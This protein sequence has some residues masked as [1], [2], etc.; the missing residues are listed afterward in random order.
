MKDFFSKYKSSDLWCV[1][2]EGFNKK[3]QAIRESQLS[4]GNGF[5]GSRGA[6]EEA[7]EG[8][9][10][11][12]YINGI[13][14]RLTSQVAELVN[15]PN[16][17][18]F[19]ITINGEK[20]GTV[21]MDIVE[22]ERILN[23]QNGLV[24]RHT[25]Y[26][27]VK[28]RRY[29]YQSVRFVSAA[30]KNFGAIRIFLTPMTADAQIEVQAD[31]DVGVYNS[32]VMTEGN[33][34][35]FQVK[36]MMSAKDS[37]YLLLETLEKH[38]QVIY[39]TG[40]YYRVGGKKVFKEGNV[41]TLKVK[42]GQTIALTKVF[43]IST[44]EEGE[45]ELRKLKKN[46]EKSFRKS[47]KGSLETLTKQHIKQWR[48]TWRTSDVLIEGTADI[49]KNLRFN[50]YHMIICAHYDGGFSSVG[51]R[52]LSGEGYRGHIFWDAEIFMLPFYAYAMPDIAKNMLLYRYNRLDEARKIAKKSGY[53]GIMFPWESAGTG[54][55]ETPTWAKNLDGT[56]IR[57][58]TDKLEHH[59]TADV[60][61]ACCQYEEIS[62][63]KEFMREA[64][65]EIVLEAARFWASRVER[66]LSG[67]Y[68]I[69]DVIGPDEFHEHVNNN[70][71]TN[72]MAKWNLMTAYRIY[73][74][75]KEKNKKIS[76]KLKSKLDLTDKEVNKWRLIAPKIVFNMRVDKVIE[77]F[78]GFFKRK[79]IEIVNFD[80]N[81]IPMLPEGVKIKDYN[82]TQLVKQADVLMLLYLLPDA[83]SSK[84]K[85]SNFWFYVNRTLHKSS[86]SPAMHALMAAEVGDLSRAYQFFNV[87]LRAD[88]SNLHGNTA[89]GIHAASLG[90]VW[91]CVVNGFAGVRYSGNV[92]TIKPH[93]P[94]T[95]NKIKC[96]IFWHGNLVHIEAKNTNVVIKVESKAKKKVKVKIFD[97]SHLI[98]PN[99][100][101]VFR[102]KKARG[103]ELGY[104]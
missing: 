23:M 35:H 89:E 69:K 8:S 79:Y 36:E 57:I 12:T 43:H 53:K 55:E 41:L 81:F 93:M 56:I 83:Y 11:G 87:A 46:S 34:R 28:K 6:L 70:A 84:V 22:H 30:D 104:Y 1:K 98:V 47:F 64:G 65:Y 95:W 13:Y 27:D 71:Y 77:E 75:L 90:G 3:I 52:T 33:K 62:G 49:Q 74:E 5:M 54:E 78:D 67:K 2:E 76:K 86:L 99:K 96:S 20:L 9:T 15:F 80:E 17:F 58:K 18:Y 4:I 66:N 38:Q 29:D 97:E 39:R 61:Y 51:A 37:D 103:F 73:Y 48:D 26:T 94:K 63:D 50:I 68:E 45:S 14:D 16:P 32:G 10:S 101:Y 60:A 25:V 21:A 42:K 72:I 24:T 92:L 40:F 85:E 59:I 88:V 19:K 91:Q 7:P 82:K 44:C 100:E 31:I 102:N